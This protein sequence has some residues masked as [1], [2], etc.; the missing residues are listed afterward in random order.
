MVLI[1]TG[2]HEVSSDVWGNGSLSDKLHVLT[3]ELLLWGDGRGAEEP[4]YELERQQPSAS[5]Q[6]QWSVY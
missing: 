3:G 5:R 6:V 2:E 1:L 4:G